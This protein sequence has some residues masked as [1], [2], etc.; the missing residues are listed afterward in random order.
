MLVHEGRL[1]ENEIKKIQ[2]Q[3]YC[4]YI[5][6]NKTFAIQNIERKRF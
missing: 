5:F 2:H 4:Y 3:D 6:V 1:N